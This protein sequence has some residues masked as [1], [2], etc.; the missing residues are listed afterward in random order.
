MYREGKSTFV[1]WP[2][3]LKSFI[4]YRSLFLAM[5]YEKEKQ[6]FV[7]LLISL[8]YQSNPMKRQS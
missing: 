8:G 6:E 1:S 3:L 4:F 2:K 7:F 5:L